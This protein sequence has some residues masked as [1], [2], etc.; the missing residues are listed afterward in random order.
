MPTKPASILTE[1][2]AVRLTT[3]E[4][5]RYSIRAQHADRIAAVP[6]GTAARRI[7]GVRLMLDECRV[8]FDLAR[9][10]DSQSAT[11]SALSRKC[12]GAAW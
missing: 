7:G 6:T 10:D 5:P 12:H 9:R 4:C 8:L 1:T 2:I 11:W 3:D